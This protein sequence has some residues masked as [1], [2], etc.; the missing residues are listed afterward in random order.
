MN[1]Y[2]FDE[3]P[4]GFSY[5]LF[6]AYMANGLIL[7]LIVANAQ[8]TRLMMLLRA[9][10]PMTMYLTLQICIFWAFKPENRHWI[11][12]LKRN[13]IIRFS[14]P[15][16]MFLTNTCVLLNQSNYSMTANPTTLQMKYA[17]IVKIFAYIF[18]NENLKYIFFS[19]SF[20]IFAVDFSRK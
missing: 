15:H 18:T 19:P 4:P 13:L 10:L 12:W 14:L 11:N 7:S 17:R 2:D 6:E 20:R 1:V 9:A 8:N 16:K 3:L 5:K